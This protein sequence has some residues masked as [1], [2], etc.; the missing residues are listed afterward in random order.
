M[1]SEKYI[2]QLVKQYANS[3]EGKAAIKKATGLEYS[4]KEPSKTKLKAY[5]EKMKNILYKYVNPLIKSISLNDIVVGTPYKDSS[6]RWR[7]EIS[8]REGSLHRESLYPDGYPDGLDNIILLFEGGYSVDNYVY[9]VWN[10]VGER[11][12]SRK[13]RDG[14]DFL[15]QAINEFN[16][17]DSNGFARAELLGEYKEK[18]ENQN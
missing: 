7:L 3:P 11:V 18:S 2:M 1:I 16:N 4:E 6:G 12:R 17:G 15:V 8:F 10:V 14:N 5:G 13:E 9:G